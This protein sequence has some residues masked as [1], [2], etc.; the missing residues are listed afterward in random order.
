METNPG[1]QI[2]NSK[3]RGEWAEMRF[4]T[5]AA[6]RGLTVS[7]PWGDSAAYDFTVEHRGRLLR[8]QIKST[9]RIVR[10]VYRCH[11]PKS[12]GS[13]GCGAAS[14]GGASCGAGAPNR[15]KRK[16]GKGNCGADTAVRENHPTSVLSGA[17]P[18]ASRMIRR[19]RRTPCLAKSPEAQR[20]ILST[21]AC[22]CEIYPPSPFDFL[23]CYVIPLDLWYIFP[24]DAISHLRGHISLSP[25]RPPHKYAPYQEAWHLVL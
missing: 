13:K 11:L 7:K 14:C 5:R 23:A 4:M 22:A 19:S 12:C 18:F 25:H 9:L 3:R 6:E 10:G 24:H 21:T 8:V 20:G 1:I 2:K 16:E 15:E 17:G